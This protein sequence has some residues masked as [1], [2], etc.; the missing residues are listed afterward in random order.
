M[1]WREVGERVRGLALGL[2]ELGAGPGTRVSILCST[3][4]EWVLCDLAVLSTGAATTTI[5]PSNTAAES[6]FVITDSG[7]TIVIAENDD[8]VA[9]LTSVRKELPDVTHVVVIDGRPATTGWVITLD[10]GARR[11]RLRRDGGRHRAGRLATL[12]YTS[13]TTGRP[14]A[15]SDP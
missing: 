14:R 9:K 4:V 8:Q 12:I 7:S 6:A 10:Y 3:R 13:G 11:G 2:A 5:Y 1:S 15:S